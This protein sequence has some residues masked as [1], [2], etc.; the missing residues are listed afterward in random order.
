MENVPLLRLPRFERATSVAAIELTTRDRQ[1]L[2]L[3]HRYR[4]LRSSH[5]KRLLNGSAQNLQRR[6]RLL[7]HH[8]YLERPRAQ[9]EYYHKAVDQNIVY[10]LGNKGAALVK[11]TTGRRLHKNRWGEKNRSVGK[12][13]L[14][15]A[16]LV[17]DIMV[18][19]EIACSK[20][21]I[22]FLDEEDLLAEAEQ[23]KAFRWNVNINGS[24]TIGLIPDRVFALAFTNSKGGQDR[25]TYFLEA[26]RGTMPVIRKTLN[27]TSVYR[28]MLAYERTWTS[29]IHERKFQLK[30]FRVLTATQSM[31]RKN[32][33][34]E[35]CRKLQRGH[36]LFLFGVYSEI[37]PEEILTKKLWDTLLSEDPE[38]L[39]SS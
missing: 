20:T 3:V 9:L 4:F 14:E 10:G 2:E 25:V 32:A 5:L 35:A 15:H 29:G 6:L 8:G 7:Y 26:D 16:L 23:T 22:R 36:G 21:G 39:I 38:S 28:K 33:I 37:Q 34:K 31:S 17:A 13:F 1:I 19:V 24:K 12:V 18:A 27:Q 30:R 11:V